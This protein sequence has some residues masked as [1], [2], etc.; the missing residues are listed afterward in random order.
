MLHTR[1]FGLLSTSESTTVTDSWLPVQS[2]CPRSYS[3]SSVPP[4]DSFCSSHIVRLF[5]KSCEDS[6]TGSRCQIVSDSNCVLL[7][8]DACTV[9][10]L[11]TCLISAR[12]PQSTLIW[13]HLWHLNGCCQ[14]PGRKTKTI[15]PRAFYFASSAVW[16]ALP[17][18]LRDPELSLN[19]FKTKLKTHFFS[20][21]HLGYIYH[22]ILFVVRA[23][24]IFYK[25]AR[26]NV[27]IE[28]N[29]IELNWIAKFENN[30]HFVFVLNDVMSWRRYILPIAISVCRCAEKLIKFW[31][32]YC[33]VVEF[34]HRLYMYYCFN[35]T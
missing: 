8:T 16:N 30:I 2:T 28:L 27:C 14:S 35:F 24:A 33:Y 13:D 5:P 3:P 4:P 20:W 7:Y 29:W 12:L 31:L 25:L 11:T 10:L 23:N 9:S 21:S 34:E 32:L 18:H 26:A 1:W 6:C 22:L 19:S 15:G 17:V